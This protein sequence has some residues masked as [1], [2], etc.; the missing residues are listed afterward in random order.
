MYKRQVDS[1]AGSTIYDIENDAQF[2]F[3]SQEPQ[4]ETRETRKRRN[5]KIIDTTIRAAKEEENFQLNIKK[6]DLYLFLTIFTAILIL[7]AA[8]AYQASMIII[9]PASILL[10]VT[11]QVAEPKIHKLIQLVTSTYHGSVR[12]KKGTKRLT[13]LVNS[14]DT[15]CPENQT[16]SP[17]YVGEWVRRTNNIGRNRSMRINACSRKNTKLRNETETRLIE[18]R[19]YVKGVSRGGLL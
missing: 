10:Y 4:K 18:N 17:T 6:M 1:E 16:I 12:R 2:A 7:T 8:L 3:E 14:N 15:F 5:N 11:L 9:V 19:P 13:R